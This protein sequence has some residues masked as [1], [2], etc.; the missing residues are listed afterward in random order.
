M[1]LLQGHT[2]EVMAVAFSPDGRTLASAGWDG[3]IRLWNLAGGDSVC[4]R[5]GNDH[6]L[7]VAWSPDGEYLAAGFRTDGPV[8]HD[9]GNAAWF[10][11]R[12]KTPGEALTIWTHDTWPAHDYGTRCISVSPD[13]KWL[14][15]AGLDSSVEPRSR[16][17]IWEPTD[18][19]NLF[20]FALYGSTI[21]DLHYCPDGKELA[22]ISHDAG[23]GLLAWDLTK[24]HRGEER[25]LFRKRFDADRGNALAYSPDGVTVV[26]AFESGR[27]VW[28]QPGET[29]AGV[30]RQ[31]HKGAVKAVAY[32]P[33]GRT[34]LSA[35]AD[36]L[37]K[38]W[39][40]RTR[41]LL[42]TLDWQ[43]GDI[44]CVAVAPDG[45]TAAAGG[46]GLILLWDLEE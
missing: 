12:S 44:G 39:D 14:A 18:R 34:V 16:I 22:A 33:D 26:A 11:S 15:T 46:N 6:A 36:G 28:W 24:L 21:Q 32:S 42:R 38:I 5:T 7:A 37:V 23:Q 40:A 19:F 45:L 43:L 3:T 41:S 25:C 10:R 17:K 1:R 13:G 8:I 29:E 2:A 35:G 20:A 30:V 4:L 27:L 9:Y 31:A